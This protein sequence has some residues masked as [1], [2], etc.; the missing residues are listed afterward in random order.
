MY[1]SD[2]A[3]KLHLRDKDLK[4]K[5]KA[6]GFV[7]KPR[8]R[9]VND[10]VGREIIEKIQVEKKAAEVL[11]PTGLMEG[12]EILIGET[13]RV[14]NF[15][16]KMEKPVSEVIKELMKN[17]IIATINEEIDFE[18]A[19]IIADNFGY[20]AKLHID[21]AVVDKEKGIRL[22]LKKEMAAKGGKGVKI[23]PPIVTVMGH[24]D[25][26][27]TTLLDAIRETNVAAGES[28]GITQHIGAYQAKIKGKLITFLDTPGH[29]AFKAMR[30]RGAKVTDVAILIVAADDGV[31]PQTKEA[32][33]LI[34]Q[35]KVPFIVAINKVDKP[36]ANLERVK[37]ELAD[38]K[39][40]PEEW[41]G[42][43][44]MV[45]ISAKKKLNLDALLEMVLLVAEMENLQAIDEGPA[46]GTIIEQRKDSRKGA[47]ATVL[48]QNGVLKVGDFVTVG[49]VFGTIRSMEN[50]LGK[51]INHAKPST[52]V[53][54]LG[55]EKLPEVGDILQ[56]IPDK[57][58]A[59]AKLSQLRKLRSQFKRGFEGQKKHYAKKLNVLIKADVQGSLEAILEVLSKIKSEQVGLEIVDFGIGKATESDVMLA[60][61]ANAKILLFRTQISPVAKRVAEEKAIG[62]EE[63]SVIY[64]LIDQVKKY[65]NELIEPEIIE[66]K[67]GSLE[68]LGIFRTEK[69]RMIVG[70]K[71]AGGKIKNKTKV[72]VFRA[73]EMA[74]TGEISNLQTGKVNV[75]EVKMGEECGLVFVGKTR[76]KLGDRLEIIEREIKKATI[77]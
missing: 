48:I 31:Q 12:S 17:G 34:R 61:S 35:A 75:G 5:I 52:P 33:E 45:E 16:V 66:H 36:E 42:E 27:K 19:S 65:L 67:I 10:E 11:P 62:V 3:K 41:G 64:D 14:G 53:Q 54:I 28:G 55:L 4:Q 1:L 39:V 71:V 2:I 47:M 73:G 30:A 15:A 56:V 6:F 59:K 72:Q 38:L 21:Q 70:G 7:L 68:I 50:F 25:H 40:I 8:T 51:K 46:V 57:E 9:T 44:I 13:V 77:I 37:K 23:K 58:K 20:K 74:G 49:S 18:T 29:E 63:F 60:S 24:V 22:R 76:I 32:L 26:G 43:T 69:D